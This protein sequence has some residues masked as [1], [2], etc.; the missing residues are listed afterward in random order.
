[1]PA[2]IPLWEGKPPNFLEN[3]PAE[4]VNERGLI[5]NVSLPA[6]APYL[7]TKE[8]AT[9]MAIIVCA[10]GGYGSLDWKTHVIYAAQVFNPKGVAVI[11]LKYRTR[12]PH[13]VSNEGIQALTLQDAKR[14]VRMVRHRARAWGL[15]PQKIGVAGYS[16]GANLAMNLAANFDKGDATAPDPI[17]RESSR[18]DFAIG[19][20]T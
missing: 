6:I 5:K 10:G 11:G 16:A 19:L 9:G 15:D 12:P 2:P 7:P 1:M 18:P 4:T 20:A 8:R 13:L 14:A 17:E 3:A